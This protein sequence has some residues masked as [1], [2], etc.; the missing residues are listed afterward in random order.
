[1]KI[2]AIS[3][4]HLSGENVKKPMDIF[5][6]YVKGYE[7]EVKKNWEAVVEDEDI[8][9][10]SGDISWAVKL[11]D[12]RPDLDFIGKMK[13]KKII[14]KGNQDYWWKSK[15]AVRDALKEGAYALQNDCIR[16]N[17]VVICG[18]RGWTIYDPLDKNP[19]K[20][21]I[22]GNLK[23]QL[24]LNIALGTAKAN[25][26]DGDKLIVMIHYPPFNS[27]L[28]DTVITNLFSEYKVDKVVY[29]HLHGQNIQTPLFCVKNN[30]EYYL[31]SCDRVENKLVRVL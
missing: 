17:G 19:P 11:K 27:K 16:I 25:R 28:E 20:D 31:T 6:C 9:L 4:L 10:I 30:I 7:E 21:A 26:E 12:A 8:V 29:G 23:E 1:M 24:K 15:S 5:G 22:F 3:D 14:I 18:T 2:Y 13:G